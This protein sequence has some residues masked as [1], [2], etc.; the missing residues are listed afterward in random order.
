MLFSR[1]VWVVALAAVVVA[2]ASAPRASAQDRINV[3]KWALEGSE[4][5]SVIN[6]KQMLRSDVVKKGIPE[7][8][9]A[10][11]NNEVASS[12][13]KEADLDPFRDIDSIIVSAKGGAG[14]DGKMLAVMRGRFDLDKFH[15]AAQKVAKKNEDLKIST[16]GGT[17]VYEITAND[18]TFVG[19][20][21]NKNALVFT[22][23]KDDTLAAIKTV[24]TRE[25]ALNKSVASALGKLTGRESLVAAIAVTDEMKDALG[26]VPQAKE[27]APKLVNVNLTI[28]LTDEANIAML[29]GT[30]DAKS[31]VRTSQLLRQLKSLAELMVLNNEELPPGVGDVLG[32]IRIN[33]ER[34]TVVISLKVDKAMLDKLD[35]KK[36]KKD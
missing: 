2:G 23:S 18:K 1:K 27:I 7:M 13:L 32:A 21:A 26:K 34:T 9:E 3:Q 35:K 28:T 20:F 6:V 4:F 31:A 30:T 15:G 5:V 12:L 14:K 10:L 25:V 17:R 22:M 8:K 29:V 33:A 24:G 19:A 36:D 16:V 11:K